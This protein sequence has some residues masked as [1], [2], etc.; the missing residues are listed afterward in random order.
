MQ[1]KLKSTGESNKE[2][3]VIALDRCH[4]YAKG[5]NTTTA[6][7]LHDTAYD[8]Q[9]VDR[10]MSYKKNVCTEVTLLKRKVLSFH[11]FELV[12]VYHYSL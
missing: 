2:R 12:I 3:E 4:T 1:Y 6:R 9:V 10:K 7:D 8:G 11:G 5:I